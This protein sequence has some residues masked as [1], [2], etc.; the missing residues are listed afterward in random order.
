MNG[1]D[2]F[3][4][5]HCSP[6]K[7]C[8]VNELATTLAHDFEDDLVSKPVAN[9]LENSELE[10]GSMYHSSILLAETSAI[11]SSTSVS[12]NQPTQILTMDNT[13][14]ESGYDEINSEALCIIDSPHSIFV[15]VY[16]SMR[17]QCN[18]FITPA[19]QSSDIVTIISPNI[20]QLISPLPHS[21][22]STLSK[23]STAWCG[24]QLRKAID[25]TIPRDASPAVSISN[26]NS[27]TPIAFRVSTPS[28]NT[29]RCSIKKIASELITCDG[30]LA[31]LTGDV[32][33][34]GTIAFNAEINPMT[35]AKSVPIQNATLKLPVLGKLPRLNCIE[36]LEY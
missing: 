16:A 36:I 20:Q 21:S 19:M 11:P 2:D 15:K 26:Y 24:A 22:T 5:F 12:V 31:V 35:P 7:H 27:G 10:V 6:I 32:M 18:I 3:G 17:D 8:Q 34:S 33:K 14:A 25:S 1:E 9:D 23:L 28:I 13:Y 30:N 4:D 29:I